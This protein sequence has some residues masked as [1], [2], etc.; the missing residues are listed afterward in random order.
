MN[1]ATPLQI[2]VTKDFVND[3]DVEITDGNVEITDGQFENSKPS[4]CYV[5]CGV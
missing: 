4:G 3:D 5:P 2:I 1:S